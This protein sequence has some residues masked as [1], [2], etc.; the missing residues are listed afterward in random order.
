MP[1]NQEVDVKDVLSD[2]LADVSD[3]V[4]DL[5]L[6]EDGIV[7]IPP[8]PPPP[9]K[10]I[11]KSHHK[12][13]VGGTGKVN[14][15]PVTPPITPVVN[16]PNTVL[17]VAVK[18]NSALAKAMSDPTENDQLVTAVRKDTS[19]AS[20]MNAIMEEM[21][22]EV[23]FI[24]AWRNQNWDGSADLSE[25]TFRRAKMLRDLMEITAKRDA[26]RKEQSVGKI[27]FYSDNFQRV[28]KYYLET[29]QDTFHKV[30]IPSQ[31]E[32]IFFTQLAKEFGNFEKTAEKLYYGKEK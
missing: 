5:L 29:I 8:T 7:S 27:D 12:A 26:L 14:G 21:A 15:K 25:A 17:T 4:E 10:P 31:F 16:N 18:P 1:D 2:P 19:T 22:E 11:K 28:M 3:M 13:K 30:N 32:D 6:P 9:P 23:A 24:K 20:V